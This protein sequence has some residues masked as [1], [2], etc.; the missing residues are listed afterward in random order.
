ME[1]CGFFWYEVYDA[2]MKLTSTTTDREMAN[3]IRP[4]NGV[5]FECQKEVSENAD[6]LTQVKILKL[7][8]QA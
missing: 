6:G 8:I 7:E 4:L 1:N 5:V 2:D 3:L